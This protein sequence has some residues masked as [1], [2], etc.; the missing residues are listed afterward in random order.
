MIHRFFQLFKKFIFALVKYLILISL[1]VYFGDVDLIRTAWAESD[2]D[3][4]KDSLNKGESS[5]S[6]FEEASSEKTTENPPRDKGKK[7]LIIL[8]D[9]SDEMVEKPP[10]D[11]GKKPLVILDEDSDEMVEKP[12][13][14]KGKKPVYYTESSYWDPHDNGESSSNR[15]NSEERQ[16]IME[17]NQFDQELAERLQQEEVYMANQEREELAHAEREVQLARALQQ[18]EELAERLQQEELANTEGDEQLARTLQQE[19]ELAERLQQEEE[20]AERLQQE[21]EL[22]ERLQQEELANTE[23]DEQLADRL[24]QEEVYRARQVLEELVTSEYDQQQ[25]RTLHELQELTERLQQEGFYPENLDEDFGDQASNSPSEYSVLSSEIH[26]SDSEDTKNKK[27]EIKEVEKTLK[28][29][30]EDSSKDNV[31]NKKP[32]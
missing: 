28:R 26:S 24:Q 20:L 23:G 15:I 27:L 21:Q 31:S 7:P 4:T 29:A 22:A 5:K 1:V 18:E 19:E 14:D 8:D 9:D 32:K 17:R 11:K 3:D 16:F 13:R 10:R 30:H 6:G 12:P 25:A 2:D